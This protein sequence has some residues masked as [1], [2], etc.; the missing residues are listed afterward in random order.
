MVACLM[1][2]HSVLAVF[3]CTGERE[4]EEARE[5]EG[6][7]AELQRLRLQMEFDRQVSDSSTECA[8]GGFNV[9]LSGL[10]RRAL[11]VD[12]EKAADRE[13][14][15]AALAEEGAQSELEHRLREEARQ[16]LV[17][18]YS[19][20]SREA[21]LRERRALWRQQRLELGDSRRAYLKEERER[22]E[23]ELGQWSRKEETPGV[24][25]EGSQQPSSPTEGVLAVPAAVAAGGNGDGLVST[26]GD[27]S[28]AQTDDGTPQ[29]DDGTPQ[30]DDG[31]PQT[32]DG[33]PQTDD[34]T[35]QTDDGT[36]QTDD[37]T[38]QTDDG[39]PQMDDGILQTDDGTLQ[40][41]DGTLQTDDGT[42]QMDDW[43]LQTDDGTLQTDN[44]TPQT[45]DGIASQVDDGSAV[46]A[47]SGSVSQMNDGDTPTTTEFA[48][49]APRA[50]KTGDIEVDHQAATP[51]MNVPRPSTPPPQP[52]AVAK[53]EAV[54]TRM[55]SPP[56]G[57]GVSTRGAPPP[58]TIQHA[59]Y[60]DLH[61]GPPHEAFHSTRGQEPPS[62]AQ[63]LLYPERGWSHVP[64]A[65]RY[66]RSGQE[67]L[68]GVKE[69]WPAPPTSEAVWL[70]C[71]VEPYQLEYNH[72]SECQSHCTC[73][74]CKAQLCAAGMG[75]LCLGCA[76]LSASSQ[77]PLLLT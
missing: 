48:G 44:G 68:D 65:M 59:L 71:R 33:T 22:M 12:E 4:E 41:D 14:L 16:E 51:S 50:Q 75:P 72:L 36:P 54:G 70:D 56:R 42:P 32:D 8:T 7:R 3:L 24:Q 34:G 37:G 5:V 69:A 21:E 31:T 63:Y 73:S 2:Y 9:V 10:Q 26:L 52:S 55:E 20:L 27:Q 13:R 45:D 1:V 62:M 49:G 76:G 35:P 46:Q 43:I 18:H 77:S 17:E 28:T 53:G 64:K 66:I 29:T 40:T 15:R 60:P 30:T 67:E 57:Q 74:V 47:N 39:T 19:R 6:K 58:T 11:A 23:L 38:L 61:E 25:G